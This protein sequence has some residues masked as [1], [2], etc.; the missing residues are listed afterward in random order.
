[1]S[2]YVPE[3]ED[4]RGHLLQ[5]YD[6]MAIRSSHQVILSYSTSFSLA[7]RLLEKQVR[8]DIRNLYAMVRIAD[9]IVD[10]TAQ[11]AGF[12]PAATAEALD[13][14]ESAVLAAP[15]RRFHSDP[16]LHAY[17]LSA[18]RC[19][20]NPEHV[21]A[22]FS[23]MRCDL[24][25]SAHDADSFQD[26]VYGSAEVIGLLCL[27]VFLVDHPV[28]EQERARLESGARSLGA[29]FQK[30]NFLRDLAEDSETLGR[31][32]FPGMEQHGLTEEYKTRLV[33]DIRTDL[34]AA[35]TVMSLLPT[36]ARTGVLAAS[37]LFSEL[38]D[39]IEQRSAAELLSYRVS[40]P[41]RTKAAVLARAIASAARLDRGRRI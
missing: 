1:M 24:N 17:A 18:R 41:R 10:G 35:R 19:D 20:F 30:I 26:Y 12:S 13:D 28:T 33:A 22:F 9:E 37:E 11:S 5:R 34:D 2:E 29:A 40:V 27:S 36:S 14:Y 21:V 25:Q 4:D 3:T 6:R 32:Y 38:T 31:T 23:S 39:R 7:T 16:V 8:N 15:G